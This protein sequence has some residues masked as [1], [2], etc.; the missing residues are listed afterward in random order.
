MLMSEVRGGYPDLVIE[1]RGR[2][3]DTCR[4]GS[5]TFT[6]QASS[7][8]SYIII[9]VFVDRNFEGYFS[10]QLHTAPSQTHYMQLLTIS[11][12][13]VSLRNKHIR[14]CAKYFM[15][16]HEKKVC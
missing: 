9:H 13:P 10:M 11:R 8:F 2:P 16:W 14:F 1:A 3:E 12:G 15:E 7:Q 5:L 4:R 6:T